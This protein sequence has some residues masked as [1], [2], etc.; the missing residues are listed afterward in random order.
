MFDAVGLG[1]FG[2]SGTLKSLAYGLSLLPAAVLGV[3]TGVGGGV[4]RD[5]IAREV[6]ALVRPDA[7]LY[8]V[9][10][11]A[12]TIAVVYWPGSAVW[13]AVFIVVFRLVALARHWHAPT[14]FI[15]GQWPS[16]SAPNR[17]C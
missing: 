6:P 17:P 8:A 5:M 10:A 2:V 12:G 7:E 1:V 14:A 4:L 16:R 13:A 15:L 3:V 9:P 11:I